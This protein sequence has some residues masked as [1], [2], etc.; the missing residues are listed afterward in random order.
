MAR[1]PANY[2]YMSPEERAL[3]DFENAGNEFIEGGAPVYQTGSALQLDGLNPNDLAR[4]QNSAMGGIST[5]PRLADAEMAA[6][7]A[8]E[9]RAGGSGL[10]LQDEADLARLQTQ[11]NARNRG[12]QGA[13]QQEM[14][15]R[16]MTGSG[17]DLVARMQ[18]AQ[19]STD[20]EALAALEKAAMAQAGQRDSVSR[21]G[22][23][24]SSMRAQQFGEQAQKAAAQDAINRFNTQ[25]QVG[26]QQA[27]W[28]ARNQAAQANW[29]R[30]NATSD[31]NTGAGYDFRKDSMGVGQQNAQ[32]K[33][34]KATDDWN[35]KQL[36]KQ[37]KAQK[38]AGMGR[39]LGTVAGGVIGA[40]AGGPAGAAAGAQ[41]GGGLGEGFGYF[42]HGGVV[43]GSSPFPGD[44]EMNDIFTAQL[45]PGEVV[46]PK[47]IANQPE[48]ASQYTAAVKSGM[49]PMAA[50]YVAQNAAQKSADKPFYPTPT[51]API[52][53][54]PKY[55]RRTDGGG[56][57]N[58]GRT[59]QT[60]RNLPEP[61]LEALAQKNPSLVDQYRERMKSADQNLA[62]AQ[63]TRDY[64]G[65]A[66]V[67]A[68]A[69]TDFANSQ[70]QDVILKNRM[71]DLGKAPSIQEAERSRYNPM[72]GKLGDTK[73]QDAKD[74]RASA[75]SQFMTEQ[76]LAAADKSALRSDPNSEE[77]KAARAFIQQLMPNAR[78][79]ES[80]SAEQL[81]K[82]A[83]LLMQKFNAD[84][85][86]ANADR[87]YALDAMK[88]GAAGKNAKAS[89]EVAY[90]TESLQGNLDK[91][92]GLVERVGTFEALGPESAQ[93][94]S[95]IYQVAVDYAK[96]VDPE[97]VAREGE[98]AAA[99]KYMLPVKGLFVRNSTAS[100]LID[101][102]KQDV[103]RRRSSFADPAA[104]RQSRESQQQTVQMVGPDGS[105]YNIPAAE[106][107]E[108]EADG[109]KR[110]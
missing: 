9:E 54:T 88:I 73:V 13:I 31:R 90:R 24:A 96:L 29:Q 64:L 1:K 25:N 89:N 62:D 49:D 107:A 10:S 16:G 34:N 38:N 53:E 44:D 63:K 84:R 94:D 21:L 41:V 4:M 2:D 39:A 37:Q 92:K 20:Q 83:P 40:Y 14:Q 59:K 26:Q 58:V 56:Q 32:M 50:K 80:M 98:V 60:S 6:L 61:V 11:T 47:S 69:L 15:R 93:M 18:S 106:V 76:R 42:A 75:E 82:A 110:K 65:L 72:L 7:A 95:L 67:A 85:A 97:S 102:M 105:V 81:D 51:G 71:Q 36:E 79:I 68:G 99:Q 43:P 109:L 35:R 100:S 104:A 17:M 77:S 27:N 5:D 8:L 30:Q 46:L 19:A 86:Q 70:K 22:G 66:D 91:L 101:N 23:M 87:A 52:P 108:A 33:Y 48:L 3:W 74:Q 28:Q 103:E 45:T 57:P 55:D 78:G 12:R